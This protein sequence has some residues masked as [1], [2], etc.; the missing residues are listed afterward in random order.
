VNRGSD[1][2]LR[3]VRVVGRN[4]LQKTSSGK[5]ARLANKE[6]YLREQPAEE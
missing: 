6:K 5:I 1:I 3:T 4:W 2:V